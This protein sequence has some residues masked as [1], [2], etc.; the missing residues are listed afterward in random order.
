MSVSIREVASKAG[1]SVSTV[2]RALNGYTDV[3]EDT[4]KHILETA[5]QLGYTPNYIAKN[6][7][8]KTQKN[9]AVLFSGYMRAEELGDFNH[10]IFRGICNCINANG[11]TV[12]MYGINTAMQEQKS[13]KD[14]CH[15]YNLSGVIVCGLK[16]TDPYLKEMEQIDFPCVL[17][18]L[19]PSKSNKNVISVGS[20]E[21]QAFQDIT[22]YVLEQGHKKIALVSGADNA[23]VTHLRRN[24]FQ[25]SLKNHGISPEDV[26]CLQGN[27]REEEAFDRT[28]EY[29]E[30]NQRD[31]VTAFVCMS[32][33]M[34]LGV[35]RA[36]ME[37]GYRIPEDFSI[38]GFDGINVLNYIKP[39]LVTVKQN[40][41]EKGYAA[42][43]VLQKLLKGETVPEHIFI[44]H[45]IL[46]RE[47]VKK[48]NIKKQ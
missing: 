30:Q 43:D 28:I 37:A 31:R 10:N 18:D 34:A 35:Q 47:T 44:Q 27:F 14:F 7:S 1:V 24:G 8:S 4:R 29:L 32:D 13:L 11:K 48:I 45:S 33:L 36:I 22:D 41:E 46:K 17:I 16:T 26:L 19:Y 20:N 23:Q 15:E 3:N 9:M 39:N 40:I 5:Q 6:L 25:N 21:I 38:T 2:S 42:I 12:A